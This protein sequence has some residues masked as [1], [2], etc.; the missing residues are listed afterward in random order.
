M[1]TYACVNVLHDD[2]DCQT[3]GLEFEDWC[4]PCQEAMVTKETHLAYQVM[5]EREAD[6]YVESIRDSWVRIQ[7]KI[8]AEQRDYNHE[9]GD[10]YIR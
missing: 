5:P 3:A 9:R 2:I 10:V 7:A 4:E 6:L 1:N 8:K